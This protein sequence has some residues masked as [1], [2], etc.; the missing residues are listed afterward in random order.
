MSSS[1]QRDERRVPV[2][3][4]GTSDTTGQPS[5]TFP[6]PEGRQEGFFLPFIEI[7]EAMGIEL[8]RRNQ[9][10]YRASAFLYQLCRETAREEVGQAICPAFDPTE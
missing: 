5:P 10:R 8:Q 4:R 1:S 3:E 6:H 2:D 9:H 7:I